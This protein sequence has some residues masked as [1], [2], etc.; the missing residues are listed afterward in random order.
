M[1]KL[2]S[3]TFI[4]LNGYFK[5]LNE[6]TSWHHQ[7]NSNEAA[8]YAEQSSSSGSIL[9][10]GRKTYEMMYSFWPTP[11]AAEIFPTVAKN[12]NK[13]AKIVFSNSL[14]DVAWENTR[15][16]SGNI[17]DQVK[18]LKQTQGS[19]L[20]ILGSGS[21]ISQFSDAGLIDEYQI[22]LDPVALGQGTTIFSD[23]QK[24]LNLKLI[25]SKVFEKDGIVL[26]TY[27]KR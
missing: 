8:K 2:S 17:V 27:A 5:G 15:L 13:A 14:K 26:L 25:S 1:R 16:I 24:N 22:M 12:M 7:L 11:Q 6:D 23:I 21:I 9:L 19:D 10:F 3:F 4:T 20:T 18:S